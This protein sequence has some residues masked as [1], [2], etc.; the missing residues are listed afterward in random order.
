MYKNIKFL[1][2]TILFVFSCS[3]GDKDIEQEPP[4][5]NP[6]DKLYDYS[7]LNKGVFVYY[8]IQ[9]LKSLYLFNWEVGK[10]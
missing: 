5:N 6:Y 8:K 7:I 1:F 9:L 2:I 10:K 3:A 4:D